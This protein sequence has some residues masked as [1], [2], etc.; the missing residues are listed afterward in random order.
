MCIWHGH[1]LQRAMNLGEWMKI[2]NRWLK[3]SASNCQARKHWKEARVLSSCLRIMEQRWKTSLQGSFITFQLNLTDNR[4]SQ[5]DWIGASSFLALTS[6]LFPLSLARQWTLWV[7]KRGNLLLTFH[8]IN[9]YRTREGY[10]PSVS[11]KSSI[12]HQSDA[13]GRVS[14]D[15]ALPM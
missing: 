13:A 5:W 10:P 6:S 1:F 4:K 9:L 7:R 12:E 11:L 8:L 2:Q 14:T 3:Y 15:F